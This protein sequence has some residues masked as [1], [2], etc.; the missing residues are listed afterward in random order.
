MI[1]RSIDMKVQNKKVYLI[2]YLKGY[3]NSI[4][5]A[6]S[7][8]ESILNNYLKTD[9][10]TIK[11]III[12]DQKAKCPKS[13]KFA[14]YT[15]KNFHWNV[16][17]LNF[18]INNLFAKILIKK[19][20]EM[21]KPNIIHIQGFAGY[22][23]LP[24]KRSISILTMH[25]D[26]ETKIYDKKRKDILKFF[27]YFWFEFI[28]ISI[29]RAI[30]QFS[31]F[32]VGSSR[33]YRHLLKCNKKTDNIF[34]IPNGIEF[35][36]NI[37]LNETHTIIQYFKRKEK[38]N[39]IIPFLI[40]GTIQL[41]KGTLKVAETLKFLPENYHL[42]IVGKPTPIL[43]LPY[44]KK[45]LKIDNKRIHYL[46]YV[47]KKLYFK[48]LSEIDI[49]LSA[50]LYEG[51]QLVP[52]DALIQGKTVITT[53]AGSIKDFFPKDYPFFILNDNPREISKLIQKANNSNQFNLNLK[54]P[55]TWEE[56]GIK[57][58]KM[59]DKIIEIE[60]RKINSFF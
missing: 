53:L 48:I 10:K 18:L 27:E 43:G 11:T 55:F 6:E 36:H 14:F 15:H 39:D 49:I 19:I 17:I 50:S 23:P 44:L 41:R 34:F 2:F 56:V 33:M 9:N 47:Q 37:D 25:D 57:I 35:K 4:P 32:Q 1:L 38:I 22:Y 54:K 7:A 24:P 5:G 30:K 59:Y 46:G 28:R 40:V 45:I 58:G 12:S 52:L 31:Y 51:C 29:K 8:G 16:P 20:S 21:Y 42:F 13:K 3:G 26:P 60:S